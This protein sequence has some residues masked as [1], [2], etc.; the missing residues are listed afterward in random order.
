MYTT[1]TLHLLKYLIMSLIII[2]CGQSNDRQVL[3]YVDNTI[4][5]AVRL[6]TSLYEIMKKETRPTVENFHVLIKF[7][8]FDENKIAEFIK[9]FRDEFCTIQCNIY[10]YDSKSI[11]DIIDKYPLE[12]EEYILMADHFVAMS[13]FEIPD[14]IDWYPFQDIQYKN[15]GGNNWKKKP[16]E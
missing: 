10:V 12:G 4:N 7:S 1:R 9:Q 14:E 3:K 13:S 8:D 16:V 5:E 11:Q 6:D 15:Y 2:S